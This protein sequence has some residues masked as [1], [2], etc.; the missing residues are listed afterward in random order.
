MEIKES[1]A[2]NNDLNT[3]LIKGASGDLKLGQLEISNLSKGS[4]VS[5]DAY[6]NF[7]WGQG[8][9]LILLV[10]LSS[11]TVAWLLGTT[12]TSLVA[13]IA[14]MFYQLL[15]LPVFSVSQISDDGKLLKN[16]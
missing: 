12:L 9:K 3:S 10:L 6:T 7:S 5:Y 11:L 16:I 4:I 8:P 2:Y 13:N 14:Q 15:L 1:L